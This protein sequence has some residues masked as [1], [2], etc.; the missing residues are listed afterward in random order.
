MPQSKEITGRLAQAYEKGLEAL[1]STLYTEL[2]GVREN[3]DPYRG[4]ALLLSLL[5]DKG[6]LSVADAAQYVIEVR[7]QHRL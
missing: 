1:G 3:G 5:V 2:D 4:L 6:V 7:H